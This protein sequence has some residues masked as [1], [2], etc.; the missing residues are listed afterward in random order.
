MAIDKAELA[1]ELEKNPEIAT[2]A[3]EALQK[4]GYSIY[5]KAKHDEFM[6]NIRKDAVEK[7]LPAAIGKEVSKIHT[8]YDQD[9]ETA[10]GIKKTDPNEKSYDYLKR[11]SKTKLDELG[12]KIADYE[13]TIREKGDPSGVLQKKIEAAEEKARLAIEERDKK[14]TQLTTENSSAMKGV[15]L[16]NSFAEFS[17]TFVKILPPMFNRTSKMIMDEYLI[18]SVLKDGKLYVGD[19]TGGIKKDAAFKDI[20]I[21]DAFKEDFKDVIDVKRTQGGAGSKGEHRTDADP[22]PSQFTVDNFTMPVVTTQTEVTEALLKAGVPK[23]SA[24]FKEIFQK[25]ALGITHVMEGTKRIQKQ[26]GKP[27]PLGQ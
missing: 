5:D 2:V 25:H 14:I 19:G 21:E 4:K 1:T 3:V 24:A 15:I 8:Q 22:D 6:A 10:L 9:I 16:V 7:D 11:A 13:K 26:T 23:G 20:P 18:N 12:T 17:K 27:L